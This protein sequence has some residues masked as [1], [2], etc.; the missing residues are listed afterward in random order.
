MTCN[1]PSPNIRSL[2]AAWLFPKLI[3]KELDCFRKATNSHRPRKQKGKILP[4]SAAPD[5]AYNDP[6]HW[7][8]RNCLLQV[9]QEAVSNLLEALRPEFELL[10]DWG[11]C[12]IPAEIAKKAAAALDHFP[13]QPVNGLSVTT[14]WFAFSSLL[15]I[16][17]WDE[18]D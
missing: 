10:T 2:L 4:P 17:E 11:I 16:I 8:G 9:D 15:P 5:F 7:G 13:A 6:H 3:Q 12:E 14:A 1:L 18:W